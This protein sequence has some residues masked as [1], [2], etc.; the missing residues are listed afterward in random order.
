MNIKKFWMKYLQIE[1]K[2]YITK[3]MYHDE[4]GFFSSNGEMV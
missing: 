2:N 4:V 1:F 3:I